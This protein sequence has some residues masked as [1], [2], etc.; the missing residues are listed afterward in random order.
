MKK[1]RLL[2]ALLS[3]EKITMCPFELCSSVH[4]TRYTLGEVKWFYATFQTELVDE[5]FVI[6]NILHP[7]PSLNVRSPLITDMHPIKRVS[8]EVDHEF[9]CVGFNINKVS[10]NGWYRAECRHQTMIFY[11]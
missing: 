11:V 10:R 7:P 3:H 6:Y 8:K 1:N 2:E 4:I 5:S 9:N